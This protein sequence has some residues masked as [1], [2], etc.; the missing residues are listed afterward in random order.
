MGFIPF[1][2]RDLF[3]KDKFGS[4]SAGEKIHFRLCLPRSFCC[5]R[6]ILLIRRDDGHYEER[7]ML[8]AGMCGDDAEIWDIHTEIENEGLYWYQLSFAD[9][10]RTRW[11]CRVTI[12]P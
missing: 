2:S 3:F 8:W 6:A 11:F 7:D 5:N 4:V 9:R 12:C 10:K 1:N